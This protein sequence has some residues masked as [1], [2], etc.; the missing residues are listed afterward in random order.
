[1]T[2]NIQ[3]NPKTGFQRR[4]SGPERR[5][6]PL[7]NANIV[8]G[9]RIR[10]QVAPGLLQSAVLKVQQKHP[11]LG[12]RIRLEED[13]TGWFTQA[14]VPE[15][16][17]AIKPR[18]ADEDW[19]TVAAE[20][21]RQAFAIEIGPLVRV[22][23]LQSP[24]VSDLILTA[25]HSICDGRSLVYLIRDILIHLGY[26]GREPP[27]QTVWPIAATEALPPSVCVGRL[28]RFI[29]NR[30]NRK[31]NR[32]GISFDQQDYQ[33]LHQDFWQRHRT[34]I[35]R[36]ELTATQTAALVARCHQEGVTVNSALYA[37][38]LKAQ[39]QIQ[40]NA[41]GSVHTILVPVDLRDRLTQPVDEAVGFYVSIILFKLR[42]RPQQPFWQLARL[43]D[44]K[45]D[46]Q[47]TN[48]NI[49]D[50]Q[51]I[52]LVSPS[53]LDGV[54]FAKHGRCNDK[55]AVRQVKRK[56]LDQL[57]AGTIVSNLGRINIP[58]DYGAL[59]L[60][61]LLGPIAYSDG[62]EKVV[63]V[64][65][66]GGKMHLTLTYGETLIAPNI[67]AQIKDIA[68]QYLEESADG[69]SRNTAI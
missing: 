48:K 26:P 39:Q 54:V 7:P 35:L 21:Q 68:M 40:G 20:E 28:T 66:V 49:F 2:I 58:M 64:V 17:I 24:D 61:A 9:A 13:A 52:S 3:Q 30:L 59:H 42:I 25:H 23:L 6:L 67:V 36:C 65:T 55:M 53:F 5:F 47:L 43:L 31:W 22:N 8:M 19:T 15:I 63:E 38:F 33:A 51:K 60:E 69:L 14:D 12:V 11:L 57:F 50:A 18:V 37:A 1:M 29:I 56:H 44:R 27:S 62:I 32:K 41:T 4:M 16:P 45:I 46:H 34:A 10:G